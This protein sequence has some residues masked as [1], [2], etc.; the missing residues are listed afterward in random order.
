MVGC[1]Y[2]LFRLTGVLELS[3]V[4]APTALMMALEMLQFLLLSDSPFDTHAVMFNTG[5]SS[6]SHQPSLNPFLSYLQL[7]S[8][9]T[10]T[11]SGKQASVNFTGEPGEVFRPC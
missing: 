8:C 6:R 7:I 10:T 2:L 9:S 3:V 1:S 11:G 5:G 4:D